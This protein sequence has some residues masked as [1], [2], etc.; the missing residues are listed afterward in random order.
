M[1]TDWLLGLAGGGLIG[2]AASIFLLV[3]GRIMGASGIVGGL[4]DGTGHADG[5]ERLAL[6][7]GLVLAPMA[8]VSVMGGADTH[9]TDDPALI[10][11][12]GLLVGVG[13]R[14]AKGCTSG[15]GVC[16]IS[17]LSPRGALA[18]LCYIGAGALTVAVFRH[19]LGAI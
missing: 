19:G 7:A 13:T 4:I 16:G 12:A 14:L 2:I 17:R 18:T 6:I 1:Q 8:L 10:I 5:G 11:A 15:H 9:L 3:N